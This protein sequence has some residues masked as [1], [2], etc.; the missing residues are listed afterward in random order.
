[1]R[2]RKDVLNFEVT[3]FLFA[4]NGAFFCTIF[5]HQT[6]SAVCDSAVENAKA[7]ETHF[8]KVYN[9]QSDV[10]ETVIDGLR[11]RPVRTDVE[12]VP[13]DEEISKAL[14]IAKKNKATGDS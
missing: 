13:T 3:S 2:T 12:C 11:Q 4:D 8:E 6:A 9:T 5:V 7:L 10:D 1:M 14:Q